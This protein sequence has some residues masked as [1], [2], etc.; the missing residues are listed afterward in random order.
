MVIER[1]SFLGQPMGGLTCSRILHRFS[2]DGSKDTQFNIDAVLR[3]SELAGRTP[4]VA[5]Y[6]SSPGGDV[7]VMTRWI[8]S[9]SPEMINLVHF[10][11]HG[12]FE[13][14]IPLE[15]DGVQALHMARFRDGKFIVIAGKSGGNE[16]DSV[17]A[18]VFGDDGKLLQRKSIRKLSDE[19]VQTARK[20]MQQIGNEMR[21][22]AE[23]QPGSSS[24]EKKKNTFPASSGSA[25][26]KQLGQEMN[27]LFTRTLF[28]TDEDGTVYM[29]R[30]DKPGILY[31]VASDLEMTAIPLGKAPADDPLAAGSSALMN[32]AVSAGQLI[33]FYTK[34]DAPPSL[35]RPYHPASTFIR[36]YNLFDGEPTG[37]YVGDL[38]GNGMLPVGWSRE[39]ASYLRFSKAPQPPGLEIV[40]SSR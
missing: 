26:E 29:V 28:F 18:V 20:Q 13:G 40:L 7:Y 31:R 19:E 21:L 24:S 5:A 9:R 10:D 25:D 30:P 27:A 17:E 4:W 3:P 1:D 37:S 38:A 12:A 8:K 32:A 2:L 14:L 33:L 36:T 11:S 39:G 15:I 22:K 23:S 16:M 6:T 34:Y 35:I